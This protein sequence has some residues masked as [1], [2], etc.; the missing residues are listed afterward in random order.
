[1]LFRS[2]SYDYEVVEMDAAQ[3]NRF[4]WLYMEADYLQWLDWASTAGIEEK[5]M[6][7]ISTFPE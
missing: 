5:V 7:F 3:Q 2:D 1:M 4:V 6:E